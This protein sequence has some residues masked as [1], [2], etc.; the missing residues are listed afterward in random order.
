MGLKRGTNL[1]AA[2]QST[3]VALVVSTCCSVT[4]ASAQQT[5]CTDPRARVERLIC[6]DDELRGLDADV[7]SGYLESLKLAE[8]SPAREVQQ[9]YRWL[10]ER[11]R[12][13]REATDDERA[14]CLRVSYRSRLDVVRLRLAE[15]TDERRAAEQQA[16]IATRA[17]PPSEA[18]VPPESS[19]EGEQVERSDL[20]ET[21]RTGITDTL[22]PST[23]PLQSQASVPRRR[24]VLSDLSDD[25]KTVL[26]GF[27]VLGVIALGV[28]LIP[29]FVAFS[30]RHRNRWLIL[31]LNLALGATVIGWLV[32]LIWSLNKIDDPVK[33]GRSFDPVL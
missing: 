11:N 17:E 33:G 25:E 14:A 6:A 21:A 15:L 4:A 20:S 32:A 31:V 9:Q 19:P 3:V 28:F 10:Q 24:G 27:A 5:N 29:S 13:E 16:Q 22:V 2:T 1:A 26:I 7:S 23:N 8:S 18:A 30:R 12:C